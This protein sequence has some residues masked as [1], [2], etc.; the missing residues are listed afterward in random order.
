MD[1]NDT[2]SI[3]I[4]IAGRS[5]PLKIRVAEEEG[6][7][8][9]VE[10][11]NDRIKNFQQTYTN[12]DKQDHIAMALLVYATD[13]QRLK[14]LNQEENILEKVDQISRYIDQTIR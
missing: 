11:I 5:Y 2:K 6:I 8:S 14:V 12:R 1:A 10:E 4:M 9:I 3:N 7:R 13:L